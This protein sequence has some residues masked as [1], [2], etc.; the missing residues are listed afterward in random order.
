M[1][2]KKTCCKKQLNVSN[3]S[4]LIDTKNNTPT[5]SKDFILNGFL[6][7]IWDKMTLFY[8]LIITFL[9][10]ISGALITQY[11]INKFRNR[12]FMY[13]FMGILLIVFSYLKILN[14]RGFKESFS[15]YD[16]IAYYIPFYGYFYPFIEFGLGVFYCIQIYPIVIN[17]IAIVLLVINLL[18]VIYA[19]IKN[20]KL[21]C[22]C[23]GSLGFKLPLSYITIIEDLF[24][25]IMACVMIGI[26]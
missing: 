14:V 17:S 6:N 5:Q 3:I 24:M 21:E 16:F 12:D 1:D 4:V 25:I 19:L 11:P 23:M 15:K 7:K 26:N 20:K 2:N 8:P 18:E 10:V 22:A 9:F 13:N